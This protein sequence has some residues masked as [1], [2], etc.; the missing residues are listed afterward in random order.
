MSKVAAWSKNPKS[1]HQTTS[2]SGPISTVYGSGAR[3]LLEAHTQ[4]TSVGEAAPYSKPG[5]VRCDR[6]RRYAWDLL[7]Y[8]GVIRPPV[9]S[10]DIEGTPKSG[11]EQVE[12]NGIWSGY[13]SPEPLTPSRGESKC[14]ILNIS[15]DIKGRAATIKKES[16]RFPSLI[17]RCRRKRVCMIVHYL[18][19]YIS[20]RLTNITALN[21][22]AYREKPL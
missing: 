6:Q 4:P 2:S 9:S 18:K 20:L 8:E 21:T 10:N 14:S 5:D 13:T 7:P 17:R 1:T 16:A 12:K 22:S 3:V 11:G 15:E 19:L